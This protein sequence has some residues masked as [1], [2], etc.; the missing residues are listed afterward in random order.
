MKNWILRNIWKTNLLLLIKELG[1]WKIWTIIFHARL[2]KAFIQPHLDYTDIIYDKPNNMN[3]CNK[4]ESIQYN[5]ALAITGATRGSSKEKLYQELR[6]EY[7]SSRR[8]LRKLCLFY[9][10]TANKLPNNLYNYVSTV[11]QSYQIRSGIKLEAVC[12]RTDYFA[13]SF[14]QYTIKECYNLSPEINQYCMRF[15]KMHY[16]NSLDLLPRTCFMF[17]TFLESKFLLNCV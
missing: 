8:W 15:L 2:Y 6:F 17:V 10:I 14:S 7:L 5:V 9:K 4:I 1:R 3:I 16:W 11:N 13:N 12:C